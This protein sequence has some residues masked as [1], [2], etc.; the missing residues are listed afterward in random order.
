MKHNYN[1]EAGIFCFFS[2]ADY[3]STALMPLDTIHQH[4]EIEKGSNI[5]YQNILIL[6]P[7]ALIF[8]CQKWMITMAYFC[9]SGSSIGNMCALKFEITSWCQQL[10]QNSLGGR[11]GYRHLLPDL[12]SVNIL[13]DIGDK[14]WI[15]T[16]TG[17][18]LCF[19]QANIVD[20]RVW[21]AIMV[22]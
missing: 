2:Y 3:S 5:S 16:G 10:D 15:L 12:N 8:I 13:D 1:L 17:L 20:G 21:S 4:S 9:M 14:Y 22:M 11:F 7:W 19:L 18:P 6:K